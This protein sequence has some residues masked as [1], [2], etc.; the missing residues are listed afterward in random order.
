MPLFPA[1][2]ARPPPEA[3]A[4]TES[5]QINSWCRYD[6]GVCV[7]LVVTE[8][9]FIAAAYSA[10]LFLTGG[11]P[12]GPLNVLKFLAM[13]TL[14]S[15]SARMVSDDLGNKLSISATSGIGGKCV[16]ILAP[17]FVGW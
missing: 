15:L 6:P 16:S 5:A 14:L 17:R 3:M 8:A 7:F 2:N 13:F 1:R 9:L 11:E 12:P 4:R 10:V